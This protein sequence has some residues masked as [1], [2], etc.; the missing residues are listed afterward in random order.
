MS[1]DASQ[2]PRLAVAATLPDGVSAV[3]GRPVVDLDKVSMVFE[4]SGSGRRVEALR[5]V[6]LEVGRGEFVSLIGPSGCGK[7]TLLRIVGELPS[8]FREGL[9]GT[10]LLAMQYYTLSPQDLWATVI[11]AA[12]LGVLAFVAV[13]VVERL[14]LR[15]QR[16]IEA[17]T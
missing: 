17:A 10:I 1:G 16:P 3:A 4:G 15:N 6:D 7:S 13:N 11:I 14:T 2:D 5:D 12:G 8:G 9:G